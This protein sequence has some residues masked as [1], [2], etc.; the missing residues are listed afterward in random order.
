MRKLNLTKKQKSIFRRLIRANE[1]KGATE[2]LKSIYRGEI[3]GRRSIH[4]VRVILRSLCYGQHETD[5]T[6]VHN[7]PNY[8]LNQYQRQFELGRYTK[9]I[10]TD[11]N[12]YV[13]VE[14][15]CLIDLSVLGVSIDSY[16]ETDCYYCEGSGQ[17]TYTHRES[18]YSIDADCQHCEGSGRV[19]SEDSEADQ[20]RI[21]ED[22]QYELK[23]RVK[24]LK[25]KGLNVKLDGSLNSDDETMFPV[26]FTLIYKKNDDTMLKKTLEL[27]KDLKAEVN[28]SCG[29]HVHLDCRSLNESQIV[30]IG[31]KFEP[32]L[33]F[34]AAMV[35]SSRRDN[36][37]C[38]LKVSSLN[39]DRYSA[40][41]LTS[42][43]KY[44][45]IEIRLHSGTTQYEKISNWV[46]IIDGIKNS[47]MSQDGTWETFY[48]SINAS[49]ELIQYIK[50]RVEKFSDSS[51]S[52]AA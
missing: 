30:D 14:I 29:L 15:E 1:S 2:Y 27:L 52:E 10:K 22:L 31:A 20:E 41:N 4:P 39:G 42:F 44:K 9:P 45:T 12:D 17:L 28:D 6:G 24:A 16:R 5:Q 49:A 3:F 11:K 13:G 43:D 23:E 8:F 32:C 48:K 36:K 25:I 37:Y 34:L 19:E 18:G 21:F 33:D 40:V 26:E 35:P 51:Q 38:A 7:S 50:T 46:K 47:T